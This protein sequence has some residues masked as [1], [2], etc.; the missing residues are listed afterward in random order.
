MHLSDY[1]TSD[2]V[3]KIEEDLSKEEVLKLMVDTLNKKGLIKDKDEAL[4]ALLEREKLGSTGIGDEIAI[5]HAKLTGIDNVIILI[6]VSNKGIEFD[7]VD[8]KKVKIFFLVL[9]STNKLHLHLKT[10]A[11]ISR[12]IKA[13]DFKKRVLSENYDNNKILEILNEE[14]AKL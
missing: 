6:A 13:T 1:V 12:L 11:R 10:L 5:P 2:L 8:N 9:A 3:I 14:E 7:A 4:N